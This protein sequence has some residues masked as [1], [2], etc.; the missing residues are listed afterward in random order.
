MGGL[1]TKSTEPKKIKTFFLSGLDSL[2]SRPNLARERTVEF[3]M[4]IYEYDCPECS[5]TVEVIQKISDPAPSSCPQCHTLTPLQKR[6][7]RSS[8]RLKGTGWYETDFKN[9]G[10]KS[11]KSHSDK[12][13]EV[14]AETKSESKSETKPAEKTAKKE[15]TKPKS[16]ASGEGS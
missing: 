8:F 12:K 3:G 15:S 13:P 10:K 9:K 16:T 2:A 5:Q 14:K 6:V 4:P 11:E 1:P 7:S